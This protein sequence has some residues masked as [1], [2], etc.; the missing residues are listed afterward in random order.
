M[1]LAAWGDVLLMRYGPWT[2]EIVGLYVI[3]VLAAMPC[4]LALRFAGWRPVLAASWGLYLLYQVA[5]YRLTSTEFES[6][7]PLL[8]WQLLF[9]HGLAVGYH[10]ESIAAH[11]ARWPKTAAVVATV[12]SLAFMA[13]AFS[14]PHTDGPSWLRWG[15]VSAERFT[16]FYNRYFALSDLGIGRLLNLAVALPLGYMLLTR[17]WGIARPLQTVFV[18]L[19]RQSLGAFVLHVYGLLLVANL[20]RVDGL[21][22]NTAV[23]I[24]LV[25]AIAG[26]LSR[27]ESLKAGRRA[28][29]RSPAPAPAPAMA[30]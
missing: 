24:L 6:V 30:A 18:P 27:F 5:Q 10:R 11:V 3:L 19:G 22:I 21:W 9:V 26:L 17:C 1:D 13:F 25:V 29:A 2:F 28:P 8:A 7:F 15:A 16:Y 23:Q 14:N 12:G 4:L 20:L